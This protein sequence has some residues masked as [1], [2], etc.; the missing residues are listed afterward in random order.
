M[1]AQPLT[2]VIDQEATFGTVF[3]MACGPRLSYVT[4]TDGRRQPSGEQDTGKESGLPKWQVQAT[5]LSRDGET[6]QPLKVGIEAKTNPAE[7]LAP[8]TPVVFD[9]LEL[10]VIAREGG[11]AQLWYRAQGLYPATTTNG[12]GASRPAAASSSKT[13]GEG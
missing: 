3:F 10:G 8:G 13:T 5:A 2:H 1:P 11:G 12:N 4:G 7:G 6:Q 9:R